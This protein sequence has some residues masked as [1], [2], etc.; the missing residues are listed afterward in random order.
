VPPWREPAIRINGLE[1]RRDRLLVPNDAAV[2]HALLGGDFLRG[3]RVWLCFATRRLFVSTGDTPQIAMTGGVPA[4]LPP[5]RTGRK[6]PQYLLQ[7]S[8]RE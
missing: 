2:G 8:V 6:L 3:R 5:A 1:V 4:G 7:G